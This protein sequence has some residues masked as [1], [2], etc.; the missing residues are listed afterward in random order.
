[1]SE[2][3]EPRWGRSFTPSAEQ[4][5]LMP[6][7]D[8]NRI[9]GRGEAA[10]RPPSPVYWH[11]PGSLPHGRQQTWMLERTMRLVPE[12]AA[13]NH[14]L[15]GRG[16]AERAAKADEPES[17]SAADWSAAVKAFALAH[18]ADQAGIAEMRPEWC[19]EGQDPGL[20]RIVVLAV[21]MDQADLA[22]APEP[23]SIIEVMRQYNR[24]T[25]A[26]R[27][28]ADFIRRAGYEAVPHGGPQAGP[29]L[30]I[31]PALEAGFGEL[32][33]HGSIINRRLGSSFRLA[34]VLTDMPLEADRPDAFGADEFCES[35]QVCARACPPDA[36]AHEK[37]LVRGVSRWYVD[38]EKCVPYFNESF[39]CGI[40]IAEC[41]WS[42]PGVADRLLGKLARRRA[43]REG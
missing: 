14:Q 17:R 10:V 26:A 5:A 25:R 35:C 28:L 43:T 36:I 31:P 18:E 32:G 1:M 40:C 20:P 23:S 33:K 21:A 15:G 29:V 3:S 27:A 42:R 24:G 37:Q 7:A 30:L 8:G 4:Q 16:P 19:F 11:S 41:P 34:G 6:D 38:F 2:D 12:T 13:L 9:N 39:G 22:A